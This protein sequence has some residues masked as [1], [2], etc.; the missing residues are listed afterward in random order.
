[1]SPPLAVPSWCWLAFAVV[2]VASLAVDLWAHRGGR[3]LSRQ[4]AIGWSIGWVVLSLLFGAGVAARFGWH[5]GIEFVAA[6]ATEKSL[7]VDNL[8]LFVVIFGRLA[9]P[10]AEQHRV[11]FWGILGAF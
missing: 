1:M 5:A 9:I 10:E 6:Y 2:V 8:F 11:L 7:S 4:W 3:S